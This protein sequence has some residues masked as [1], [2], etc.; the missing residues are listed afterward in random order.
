MT[1]CKCPKSYL[2]KRTRF[3]QSLEGRKDGT[4]YS[5]Y[6]P[7]KVTYLGHTGGCLLSDKVLQVRRVAA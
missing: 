7:I 4:S 3:Y 2:Q 1:K 5:G 6:L